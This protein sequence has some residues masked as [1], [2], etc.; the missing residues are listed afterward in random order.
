[1]NSARHPTRGSDLIYLVS[2]LQNHIT[3]LSDSELATQALADEAKYRFQSFTAS[4][5]VTLGLSLRKRFRGSSRHSKH[6]RGLVISI[7]TIAGHPLFACTVSES[8]NGDV[9]SDSWECLEAMMRVVRRTGHSSYYVEKGL[10]AAA[11]RGAQQS[12]LPLESLSGVKGGAFP[13]WLENATCCPI[14]IAAVYGGSSVE[15]HHLVVN[16]I[17]DYINKMLRNSDPTSAGAE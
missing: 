7:Q 13:I 17:R 12:N 5:A 10:A 2:S 6:G 14:A 15:D 4:D 11:N 8:M 9:G 1:M 16:T 3:M